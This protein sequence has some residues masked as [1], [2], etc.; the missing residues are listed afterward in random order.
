MKNSSLFAATIFSVI[1]CSTS[2]TNTTDIVYAEK[3]KSSGAMFHK[4]FSSGY[5]EKN[6]DL[7]TDDIYVNSNNTILIGRDKLLKELSAT[8]DHFLGCN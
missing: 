4:N 6:G 7:V 8:M 3:I 2:K 1:S 5:F